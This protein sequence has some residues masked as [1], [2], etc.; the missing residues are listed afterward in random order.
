MPHLNGLV[1]YIYKKKV[2]ANFVNI[3]ELN[4]FNTSGKPARCGGVKNTGLERNSNPPA[5]A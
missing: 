4:S 5:P 1:P 3:L 2:V